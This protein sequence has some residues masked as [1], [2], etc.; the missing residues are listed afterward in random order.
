MNLE[1]NEVMNSSK[2]FLAGAATGIVGVILPFPFESYRLKL[3]FSKNT[4]VK[5]TESKDISIL[6]SNQMLF[7]GIGSAIIQG[8]L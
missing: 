5:A 2:G 6:F 1:F 8:E 4:V 3:I 7:R